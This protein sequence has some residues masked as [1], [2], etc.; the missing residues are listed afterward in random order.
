MDCRRHDTLSTMKRRLLL[1]SMTGAALSPASLRAQARS[2]Y[3]KVGMVLSAPKPFADLLVDTIMSGVRESGRP[4]PQAEAILR[5]SSGDASRLPALTAELLDMNVSVLLGDGPRHLRV[6]QAA[7]RTV[8]I[9]AVDFEEDPVVA[10]YAAS[11]ARPGGNVTGIFLDLPDFTGKWIEFLRECIPRLSSL[12]LISDA[13]TGPTQLEAL[14]RT[15]GAL[16]IRTELFDVKERGDYAGAVGLAK[17]HGAEAAI[18]LST[19]L[20]PSIVKDLAEL[21]LRHRMPTI[22][23]LSDFARAGGLL[24]YGPNLFAAMKQVGVLMGKVLSGTAPASLPVERPTK[25]ELLANLRTA[26]AFGLVIPPS[27]LAR[28]DEVIE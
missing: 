25:F 1:A 27:I 23:M 10:G 7:T 21:S 16:G 18:L 20:I 14:T 22:T 4:A 26:Q 28:A 2:G 8:P 11:I 13:S 9:V 6:A 24:S 3:P 15:A 5:L 17:D 12:A 19:P